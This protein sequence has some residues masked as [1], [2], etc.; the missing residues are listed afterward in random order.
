MALRSKL[1]RDDSRLQNCLNHDAAHVMPGTVGTHVQKIQ[2]AVIKLDGTAI[3]PSELAL[4]RYGHSTAA[5]VLQYKQKRGIVNRSY[6]SKADNI[7]G[8]MTIAAL[9]QE[10]VDR[11]QTTCV[12]VESITCRFDGTGN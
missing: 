1:F 10:L 4:G 8:K 6:Q 2:A 9:D 11:E 7:V 3:E 5:A 12:V